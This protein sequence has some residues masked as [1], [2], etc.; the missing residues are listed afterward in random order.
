M[1]HSE[2]AQ[3][4]GAEVRHAAT[5]ASQVIEDKAAAGVSKVSDLVHDG[6]E[7]TTPMP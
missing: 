4:I 5:R 2:P 1:S 6:K 3:Q 7:Q